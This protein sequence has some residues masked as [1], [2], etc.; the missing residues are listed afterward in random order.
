MQQ[1]LFHR[2]KV[3]LADIGALVSFFERSQDIACIEDIL[4]MIIPALSHG[5]L[6]SSFLEHVN[7]L[8]GCCIFLNLLER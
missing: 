4:N 1:T 5:P 6:L 3:S 2:L 8:G 7:V